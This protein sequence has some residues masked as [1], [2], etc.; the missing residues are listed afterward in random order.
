MT[1]MQIKLAPEED[2]TLQIVKAR[3]NL[4][5]KKEALTKIIRFYEDEIIYPVKYDYM[6]KLKAIDKEKTVSRKQLMK[7]LEK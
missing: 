4:K 3:F 1:T 7:E 6:K 2:M 5:T